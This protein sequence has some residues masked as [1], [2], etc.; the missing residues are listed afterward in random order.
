MNKEI[1]EK[2]KT[3]STSS[4]DSSPVGVISKV[5]TNLETV[6]ASE[7]KS[8]KQVDQ[9]E[10]VAPSTIVEETGINLIPTMTD[11]EIKTEDKKKRVNL[12][13]LIS[14]SLLFSVTILVTGFNIISRMQLDSQKRKLQEVEKRVME[15]SYIT[16]G[17]TEI[18]ER[19]FLFKDIQ[20]G[21][22]STRVFI[23]ELRSVANTSGNNVINTFAFPGGEAF[24]ISGNAS[25]LEDIAKFWY[26]M[27][28][29]EKFEDVQ[30]RSFSGTGDKA[31]YSFTGRLN[32][33]EFAQ[34]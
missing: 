14:L 9:K 22:I 15:Y 20:E 11:V 7:K 32:L 1:E 21:R 6:T 28:N 27:D 23:E 34:E 18:L 29:H 19:I 26:L 31:S 25:S 3:D 30:L 2:I 13:S 16:S 10:S 24:E 33:E 5:K 12:G 17:N 8:K 4:G